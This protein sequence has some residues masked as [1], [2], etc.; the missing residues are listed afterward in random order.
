MF[1]GLTEMEDYFAER[2]SI[3]VA[4]GPVTKIPHSLIKLM[5]LGADHFYDLLADAA[6]LFHVYSLGS[7][8]E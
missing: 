6:N 8:K 4:L 3:F 5:N 7:D 1:Y 2:V